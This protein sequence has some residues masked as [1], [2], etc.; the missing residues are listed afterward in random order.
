MARNSIDAGRSHRL[1]TVGGQ[2]VVEGVMMRTPTATS[3]AVRRPDRSVVVR[4]RAARRLAERYPLLAG[5]GLRGVAVLIETL[6]DGLSA[7]NFAASQVLPEASGRQASASAIAMTLALSLGFGFLLFAV[8]PHAV[9]IMAGDLLGIAS[10]AGGRAVAFHLV[11]G[12]VKVAVFLAF[13]FAVSQM[14][15]IRRVFQ[16]HGAEHQAVH[17]YEARLPL[18]PDNL[19]RFPPEHFRCGTSFVV[20][21]II[22]SIFVFAFVFPFM[23]EFSDHRWI[24]QV[25]YVAIKAPLIPLIAAVSYELMR[26]ASRIESRWLGALLAGPGLLIQRITTRPPDPDQQE[27]AIIALIAA[28]QPER[29]LRHSP[30]DEALGSFAS[31]AD[32]LQ[33]SVGAEVTI[34]GGLEPPMRT[35]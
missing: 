35:S 24:N 8:I 19:S 22:V 30:E 16:Y 7:L 3:V 15:D 31:F 33:T 23:P 4:V 9:T 17:A 12:L 21:V 2:A 32:F 5:P 25:A 1:L 11:D 26:A 6:S 10:L 14:K 28:L 20:M 27:V 34:E 29:L 13:L 18:R